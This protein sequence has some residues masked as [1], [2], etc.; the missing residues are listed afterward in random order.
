M[1]RIK[2]IGLSGGGITLR[3]M[4]TA[5]PSLVE[6]MILVS[7]PPY[8]PAQ[9]RAIQ[10]QAS[11]EMFGEAEMAMMRSCH[12]HGETQLQ[13]LFAQSRAFA[14]SYD[15]VNS[16]PPYLGT[17]TASTLVVFGDSDP[18]YPVSLAFE[19]KE[20]I[21]RC[22]LWIVPNGGHAPVRSGCA[23][24]CRRRDSVSPRRVG[25]LRGQGVR[26]PAN[27]RLLFNCQG[28]HQAR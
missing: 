14:D 8:F 18:F 17:I 27:A 16:T 28:E 1:D 5:S 19:L 26:E 7:A 4:A 12:R 11:P 3:H 25:A 9:A 22:Q 6:S 10:R 2:T 20:A 24:L 13:R 15:D 23:A 21:P